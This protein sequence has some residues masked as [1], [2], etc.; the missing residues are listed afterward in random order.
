LKGPLKQ[1]AEKLASQVALTYNTKGM[2]NPPPSCENDDFETEKGDFQD[3]SCNK[4]YSGMTKDSNSSYKQHVKK[5]HV[6]GYI[7]DD[8]YGNGN[9]NLHNTVQQFREVSKV[10]SVN[11]QLYWRY[12][13]AGSTF[14]TITVLI[15]SIILSQGSV[16]FADSWIGIWTS[17][18]ILIQMKNLSIYFDKNNDDGNISL[19]NSNLKIQEFNEINYY[20]LGVYC[21]LVSGSI[22]ASYV[23]V[24]RIFMMGISASKNMHNQMFRR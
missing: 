3:Y 23:M 24:Y 1:I 19:V 10:G 13:K 17:N 4:K 9:D 16:R 2:K 8:K 18:E 21:S 15:I 5:G 14:L 20:Y 6:D 11:K 22:V 7:D 12:V